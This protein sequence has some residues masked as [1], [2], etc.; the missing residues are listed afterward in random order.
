[1]PFD[2][3]CPGELVRRYWPHRDNLGLACDYGGMEL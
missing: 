1:M 3:G 2:A